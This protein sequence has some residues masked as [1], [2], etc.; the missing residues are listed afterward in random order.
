M[1]NDMTDSQHQVALI[2]DDELSVLAILARVL[3]DAGFEVESVRSGEEAIERFQPDVYS[4]V[5]TDIR[6]DGITGFELIEQLKLIDSAVK[7]VVMT[8]H[9]SVEMIK[10][11]FRIGAYDFLPKPFDNHETIKACA[12]RAAQATHLVRSNVELV[13]KLRANHAMLESANQQLRLLNE[14]LRVQANT[15]SLTEIYNR[16]FIDHALL[17]EVQRRNR[18]PDPLSVVM[19]DVDFFKS[20]N[21]NYGHE[22]GDKVLQFIAQ[23]LK[24]CSRNIDVV[25]RYGGE[26]FFVILP[27]TT[28][29]N[30]RVYAERARTTIGSTTI[31]LDDVRCEVTISAGVAGIQADEAGVSVS[32]LVNAADRALYKAKESGRNRTCTGSIE[33]NTSGAEKRT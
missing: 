15:D 21:D 20:F 13:S 25:G 16:R 10:S 29:E 18:Y 33:N 1:P 30:A 14:E 26:E 23:T 31:Q 19:I 27:K 4:V 22:G 3:N 5:I 32:S 12:Q 8:A 9:D 7:T 11:A 28:P 17:H 2:V 24:D 6:M